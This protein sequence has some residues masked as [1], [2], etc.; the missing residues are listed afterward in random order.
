MGYFGLLTG[1]FLFL[2]MGALSYNSIICLTEAIRKSGKKRYPN[3]VSY[4]LGKRVGKA[5]SH[6]IILV[7]FACVVL[8]I[9]ALWNLIQHL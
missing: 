3:I 8:Y 5:I 9:V 4:Y 6:L 1:S 7:Q 2:A